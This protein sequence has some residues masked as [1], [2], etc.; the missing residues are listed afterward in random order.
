MN[1]VVRRSGLKMWLMAIGGIPLLVISLDVLTA[2][3]ISNWLRELIFRPEDTQIYEQRDVIFAWVMLAF[4]VFLV[5]WGLKELFLPTSV[6]ECRREG[7]ALK[8]AGPIRP[9]SLVSWASLVEVGS[10]LVEDEGDAIPVLIV[11][12]KIRDGLPEDPWGARWLGDGRLAILAQDWGPKPDEVAHK[13]AECAEEAARD[14]PPTR[15]RLPGEP[16]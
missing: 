15:Y 5:L 7:L 2:R 12:L 16:E 3:R 10:G 11:D 4:A 13:I 14:E 1:L 9:K 6:I 8:L